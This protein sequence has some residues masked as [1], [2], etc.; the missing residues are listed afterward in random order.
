MA[1]EGQVTELIAD[2]E[3]RWDRLTEWEQNFLR[4]CKQRIEAG[5]WTRATV[6]QAKCL[7]DIEK[8]VYAT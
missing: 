7:D 4:G 6:R 3:A 5:E 8:K 2:A 1:T